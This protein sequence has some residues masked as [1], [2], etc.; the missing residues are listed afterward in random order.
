MK[1]RTLALASLLTAGVA[2]SITQQTGV[3]MI[4]LEQSGS[5][6]DRASLVVGKYLSP[7]VLVKY[8][9]DL[10]EQGYSVNMEYWLRGG[11]RLMT[12]TSRYN[13]SGM[14]LNWTRD[15]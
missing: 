5:T 10:E 12:T 3:D 13:Q 14:E 7:R 11:L 1:K 8:V 2:Q 6:S 9:H 15:Y 4:S